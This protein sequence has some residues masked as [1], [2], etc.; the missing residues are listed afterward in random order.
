VIS[1]HGLSAAI[2][3]FSAAFVAYFTSAATL[4]NLGN[5]PLEVFLKYLYRSSGALMIIIPVVLIIIAGAIKPGPESTLTFW[6]ETAGLLA[7]MVYWAV[8]TWEVKYIS[9]DLILEDRDLLAGMGVQS[10]S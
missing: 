4:P 10:G 5:P 3:F 8:K 9:D 1:L 6:I 7:F 2:F